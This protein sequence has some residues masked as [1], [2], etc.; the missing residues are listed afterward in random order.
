MT[1]PLVFADLW[2]GDRF[3]A[4]GSMWTKLGHETARQH[5]PRAVELGLRGYGYIGDTICSFEPENAVEF[6][7]PTLGVNPSA[8]VQMPDKARAGIEALHCAIESLLTTGRFVDEEGEATHAL[9]DLAECIA[10][11][12]FKLKDAHGVRD[13]HP[14]CK[15]NYC[16]SPEWC[17]KHK[18]CAHDR[19]SSGDSVSGERK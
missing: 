14:T 8:L 19:Q 9:A 17:A 11:P 7:P 6:V 1:E 16:E 4:H 12:P 2:V 10:N 18:A 15:V 3:N 5:S 13:T